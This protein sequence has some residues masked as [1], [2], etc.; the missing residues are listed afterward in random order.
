ML[1]VDLDHILSETDALAKIQE[2]FDHVERDGE[3]YVIT[4]ND[5]PAFAIVDIAHLE[6][7]GVS[8]VAPVVTPELPTTPIPT[9]VAPA[10]TPLSSTPTSPTT[11]EP[12]LPPLPDMPP[13][14]GDLGSSDQ[15]T[16]SPLG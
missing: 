10:T 3:V 6:K 12:S 9:Q 5:R 4:K 8:A 14:N 11:F 16:A 1:N 15:N 2:I 7:S 13:I